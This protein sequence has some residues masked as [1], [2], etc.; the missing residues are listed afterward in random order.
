MKTSAQTRLVRLSGLLLCH[1]SWSCWPSRSRR[2]HSCRHGVGTNT[3]EQLPTLAQVRQHH[4]DVAAAG[5]DTIND[6]QLPTLAQV[7][8]HH[9][10]VAAAGTASVSTAR[11]GTQGRGGANLAPL[12][13][14][15]AGTQGRG[16]VSLAPAAPVT[17]AQPASSGISSTTCWII[18]GA[19][20]AALL[21]GF[22]ALTARR[23]KQRKA[24]PGCEFLPEG[25]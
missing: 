16:G 1:C 4:G 6:L 23:R 21:I 5:S 24:S 10:D 15:Q 14:A 17:G 20:V 8:R 2:P 3:P 25:C 22:W 13:T 11:A 18:A 19:V 9:G 12:T 7:R